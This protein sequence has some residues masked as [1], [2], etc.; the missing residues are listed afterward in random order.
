MRISTNE[1]TGLAKIIEPTFEEDIY[2]SEAVL[3]SLQE[4]GVFGNIENMSFLINLSQKQWE[5]SGEPPVGVPGTIASVIFH[6]GG[7]FTKNDTG[8]ICDLDI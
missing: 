4:S 8:I 5:I 6:V 1:N 3:D 2:L 7:S